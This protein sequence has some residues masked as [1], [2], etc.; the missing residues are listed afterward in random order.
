MYEFLF[1]INKNDLPI[2]KTA[3]EDGGAGEKIVE[4]LLSGRMGVADPTS[5]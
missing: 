4:A 5:W 3:G 1:K 2:E